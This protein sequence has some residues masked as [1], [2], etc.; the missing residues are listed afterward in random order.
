M[1]SVGLPFDNSIIS[2]RVLASSIVS[3]VSNIYF[4]VI[5]QPFLRAFSTFIVAIFEEQ[6]TRTFHL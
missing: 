2:V 1:P 4:I 5:R 3:G 6:K